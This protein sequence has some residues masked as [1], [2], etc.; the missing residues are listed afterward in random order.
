[1][2]LC[3]KCMQKN[4]DAN[5]YCSNCGYD[6]FIIPDASNN[7]YKE[8]GPNNIN[9]K[10]DYLEIGI[11]VLMIVYCFITLLSLVGLILLKIDY[12]YIMS[13]LTSESSTMSD[14][15]LEIRDDIAMALY[16]FNFYLL[17]PL[18]VIVSLALVIAVVFTVITIVKLN[19][20]HEISNGLKICVLL[21]VGIVPGILLLVKK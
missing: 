19:K 14:L 2:K 13:W 3:K 17:I 10:K 15:E 20:Q 16:I 12:Q 7:P 21:F 5:N 8:S 18:L 9:P 6:E 1:M 4:N 11:K